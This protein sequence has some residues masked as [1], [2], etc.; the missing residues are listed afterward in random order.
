MNMTDRQFSE[1]LNR[2]L[3][4]APASDWFVRKVV[5]RLPRRTPP[6]VERWAYAVS[7]VAVIAYVAWTV[8]EVMS[9]GIVTVA[10][11]SGIVGS[12]AI[13]FAVVC[14]IIGA[15]LAQ[16]DAIGQNP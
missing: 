14:S 1:I 10:M 4:Q 16:T 5:N 12:V 2:D 3:P 15:K 13:V 8:S 9:T 6:P 7:L 11:L